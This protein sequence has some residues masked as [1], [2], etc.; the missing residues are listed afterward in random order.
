MDRVFL[1]LEPKEEKQGSLIVLE[2]YQQSRNIGTVL[3]I[4]ENVKSVKVGEKVIF[5]DF[6]E[7]ESPESDVVVVRERS[8][9]GVIDE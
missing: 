5:H 2:N 1:R 9:L 3:S 4:G 7:L 6:D 8:L